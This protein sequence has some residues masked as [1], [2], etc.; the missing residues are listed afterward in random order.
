[1]DA[2]EDDENN[3]DDDLEASIAKEVAALKKPKGRK[4]FANIT[5]GTDCGKKNLLF[6]YLKSYVK[7]DMFYCSC[8]YPL[9]TSRR[10]RQISTS[11]VDRFR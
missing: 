7:V 11:Y 2:D 4:R 3:D 6:C 1:M 5:T 9:Y 8:I 10:T